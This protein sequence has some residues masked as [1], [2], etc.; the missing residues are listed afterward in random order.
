MK[1]NMTVK[2]MKSELLKRG[3]R[4]CSKMKKDE[5][6]KFYVEVLKEEERIKSIYSKWVKEW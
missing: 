2:E 4:G 1:D 5:L 6:E 3:F